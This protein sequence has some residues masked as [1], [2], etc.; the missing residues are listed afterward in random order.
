MRRLVLC[1]AAACCLAPAANAANSLNLRWDDCYGGGG[2]SNKTFACNTNSGF[3]QLYVSFSSSTPVHA[4]VSIEASVD[5]RPAFSTLPSWW[6]VRSASSCRQPAVSVTS[7]PAP[8][9]TGCQDVFSPIAS[10]GLGTP[11]TGLGDFLRLPILVSVPEADSLLLPANQE[12]FYVRI[13]IS[14]VRTVGTGSCSGCQ[15]PVCL[16][17]HKILLRRPAGYGDI[18]IYDEIT[19][20]S[21]TVNW[22]GAADGSYIDPFRQGN[23]PGPDRT[24]TCSLP[25]P[26]RNGTWGS[27]KSMYH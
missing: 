11:P 8:M 24:L 20:G 10:V 22:Q 3:E 7:S 2:V 25:V 9:P 21:S 1:L 16:G 5:I 4:V 12:I 14:H 15:T 6:Q 19:P 18:L 27:I 13:Q 23:D 17:V 26:A